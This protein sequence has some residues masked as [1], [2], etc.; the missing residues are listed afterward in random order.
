MYQKTEK[1]RSVSARQR[2]APFYWGGAN[3]IQRFDVG[4]YKR[5]T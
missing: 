2:G 4:I 1:G 5:K 3:E